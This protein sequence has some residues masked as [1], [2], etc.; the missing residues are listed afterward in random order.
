MN[1]V[2]ALGNTSVKNS[3]KHECIA[4]DVA[5]NVAGER[6]VLYALVDSG[7][8][9]D[10]ISQ[11][12]VLRLGLKG[13]APNTFGKAVDGHQ[14]RLFG[15]HQL[16]VHAT[17]SQGEQTIASCNLYA[18]DIKQFDMILGMNWL[19][20]VDPD[21][22][23]R[24]GTWRVR[25]EEKKR[26]R[27]QAQKNPSPPGEEC[28]S[29]KRKKKKGVSLRVVEVEGGK[30]LD[31]EDDE[32][33]V[34]W[35]HP[36]VSPRSQRGSGRALPNRL[37][38]AQISLRGMAV[39]EDKMPAPYSE[40]NDVATDPKDEGLPPTSKAEHSIELQ[41]GAKVPFGPIY[42]LSGKELE[43]LRN[44]LDEAQKKGWIQKS[45]SP[46]GAPILFVPKKDG[47]L[48]LCVDYRGLNN[49]TV[50]NRYPL[51]L[52]AEI[53]DRLSGAQFFTKFDLRDAYHRLGIRK[54][55]RWKTAFRTRYG[56]FEYLVMPF[57]LTNAPAT[58][59]SYINEALK[60]LT[61]YCCIAYM[62][63]ILIFSKT[64]EEHEAHVKAV[65]ERLRWYKLFIKLSKCEFHVK[66]VDFLGFRVGANGISMDPSRVTAIQEWPNPKTHR[67]IQ[68]FLGFANFYRVFIE[69]Y[70]KITAPM[71]NLLKGMQNGKKSGELMWTDQA[72]EAF[73]EVKKRF[74]NAPLLRHYDPDLETRVETDASGNGLGGVLSQLF[75]DGW[76]PIAFYSRKFKDEETR[77][78][79][80][81]QEMLA[82]IQAYREWRHYLEAPAKTVTVITDHE[83]LVKFMD[84]KA[85]ARK[86]QARWAEELAVYDFKIHWRAGK[87][88]PADGLSRRPDFE[89]GDDDKKK[90]DFLQELIA[91]RA[92]PSPDSVGRGARDTT[93]IRSV[94]VAALTRAQS[95][96]PL[97]QDSPWNTLSGPLPAPVPE[98]QGADAA[99]SAADS[100]DGSDEEGAE[101]S[102][103]AQ[104]DVQ[105]HGNSSQDTDIVMS[106]VSP[107]DEARARPADLVG[108]EALESTI[109]T[110][111]KLDDFVS[112]RE[113]SRFPNNVVQG[114]SPFNGKWTVDRR[115]LIRREG[116]LYIPKDP[117]T[118]AEILRVNHDDPWS[119][120]H[121]GVAKT[122]EVISRCYWWP[123]MKSDIKEY[124]T[125]CDVCQRMKVP[126]HKP[127]GLLAPLPPPDE[128]WQGI[129]MDFIVGLPP[130]M[131]RRHVY[132]SILVV[133]DRHS[134]M[135]CLIP[136]NQDMDTEELGEV[137]LDDVFSQHGFPSSI[138]SDRGSLF[139]SR[140]WETFCYYIRVKRKL[141]T[142]F[143][144][145]TDG[146][147]ERLNQTLEC[148]LRCYLNEEQNNWASLL[149]SAQW[150]INN[151]WNSTIQAVPFHVTRTYVPRTL[152]N[153]EL[154]DEAGS[155]A[156]SG[157]HQP[158]SV[159]A[160][161][162]ARAKEIQEVRSHLQ[163]A[164]GDAQ[165]KVKKY[166][167]KHRKAVSFKIGDWVM[168]SSRNINL[169]RA[170]KKLSDKNI[171][172]F[173]IEAKL[174]QNA[175]RLRLPQQYGR[176]HSTFHV[177][178]LSPYHRRPGEEPPVPVEIE[179]EEEYEVEAILDAVG[180]GKKRRWL[181]RWK[182]WSKDHD[183]W[184]YIDNLEGAMDLVRGF[185]RRKGKVRA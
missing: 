124:V 85:L 76:H 45:E 75:A 81:D 164:W 54:S 98:G 92:A 25:P 16:K 126:R 142:A 10:F 50:K 96:K 113:W 47:T 68:V 33:Y 1:A 110:L 128:P 123:R 114:M 103:P 88:N 136:C 181:V 116:K 57:G 159:N 111:Q 84:T 67:D 184:E 59:Q 168:L 175:Y 183:T 46:A 64:E 163:E 178:L 138:V 86:R 134:K 100:S 151:T 155:P 148:Y 56:Q 146:Q 167:D 66:E 165:A 94:S 180:S 38:I 158:P 26:G 8:E 152:R 78:A 141:S 93:W 77:Y 74:Q 157:G 121:F 149:S 115:G 37:S 118:R 104:R 169:R 147:T 145:Q 125:T 18:T 32:L 173:Q 172:P 36:A 161:A 48:R 39:E 55:D 3:N 14:I 2:V 153:V 58:F 83:A 166:Y 154:D 107:A 12:V 109:N 108:Q 49:V 15:R 106:D 139:T 73:Q 174:G 97:P 185:D 21:I 34:L 137:L 79:T 87:K 20:K 27:R 62:D 112:R 9:D 117:A 72:E 23:F 160:S 19:R 17:D 61:D 5:I 4:V 28:C 31:E 6:H 150:A 42:P 144:P 105:M 13:E 99:S 140:Y 70:S 95:K 89:D 43:V 11:A 80:G 129:A 179:G 132:D 40:F 162:A 29:K 24:D 22:S 182:G 60:G 30:L 91:V 156:D 171:G 44:Y 63:D 90:N 52:I 65:L 130:S 102:I 133:V 82:I 170:M 131:H 127:H 69:G 53:L 143:H 41:P 135:V 51:P 122:T 71:T 101:V 120:G 119:G 35:Y 7:A 176:L 177:S